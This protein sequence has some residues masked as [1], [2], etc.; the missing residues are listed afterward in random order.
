MMG[1]HQTTMYVDVTGNNCIESLP[2][3]TSNPIVVFIGQYSF[4]RC[5][6]SVMKV[7]DRFLISSVFQDCVI[8]TVV[9]YAVLLVN[10]DT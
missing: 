7:C 3:N 2:A 4:P 9:L 1:S 10:H 8:E 6:V 5:G